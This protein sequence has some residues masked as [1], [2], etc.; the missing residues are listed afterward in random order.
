MF[1]GTNKLYRCQMFQLPIYLQKRSWKRL[2]LLWINVGENQRSNPETPVILGTQDRGKKKTTTIQRHLSYWVH[3]TEV[4]NNN[5][6][7]KHTTQKTKKMSNT[8]PTKTWWWTQ[9]L[10]K[11]KQFLLLIR[12]PSCYPCSQIASDTTTHIQV[13]RCFQSYLFLRIITKCM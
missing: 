7:H 6:K 2:L 5:N 8:G 3:K 4:K 1:F 11:G 12:H 13:Q 9:V 10:T